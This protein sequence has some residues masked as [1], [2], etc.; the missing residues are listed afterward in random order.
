MQMFEKSISCAILAREKHPNTSSLMRL[1]LVTDGYVE[2]VHQRS[3]PAYWIAQITPRF[4]ASM[5]Y[6]CHCCFIMSEL[7]SDELARLVKE[8]RSGKSVLQS[9]TVLP[10]WEDGGRE[11]SKGDLCEQLEQNTRDHDLFCCSPNRVSNL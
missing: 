2:H 5:L 6:E 7:C 3:T 9:Y 11:I 1:K 8:C 10:C 4:C